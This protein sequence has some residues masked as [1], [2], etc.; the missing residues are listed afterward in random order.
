MF[1]KRGDRETCT[2]T[3]LA[4]VRSRRTAA[5]GHSVG[6]GRLRGNGR[7]VVS[8]AAKPTNKAGKYG[9][10]HHAVLY[11]ARVVLLLEWSVVLSAGTGMEADS[12]G[13]WAC[14]VGWRET[15]ERAYEGVEVVRRSD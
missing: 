3:R 13:C 6:S 5:C 15:K 1:L 4:G 14:L 11:S 8:S 2:R 12:G 10:R 9:A 7:M